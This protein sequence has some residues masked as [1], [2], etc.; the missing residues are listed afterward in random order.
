MTTQEIINK[1]NEE[2]VTLAVF[3]FED[4]SLEIKHQTLKERLSDSAEEGALVSGR[5]LLHL[6][7]E[8]AVPTVYLDDVE[9]GIHIDNIYCVTTEEVYDLGTT[10]ESAK[11][12]LSDGYVSQL[13]NT[14]PIDDDIEY[15]ETMFGYKEITVFDEEELTFS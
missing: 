1:L 10:Y 8:G 7:A 4:K 9:E 11:S 2:P 14:Q 3:N 12:Y 15:W 6:S 13:T 5:E